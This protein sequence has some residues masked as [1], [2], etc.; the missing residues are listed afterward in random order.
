MGI[1]YRSLEGN[2]DRKAGKLSFVPLMV[3]VV[4]PGI[5]PGEPAPLTVTPR[6]EEP[7][8]T[9]SL[10]SRL[11]LLPEINKLLEFKN[12]ADNPKLFEKV[13]VK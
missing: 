4:T 3:V 11:G 10:G 2:I 12:V 1:W 9:E 7:I 5:P 6:K 13:E 8:T